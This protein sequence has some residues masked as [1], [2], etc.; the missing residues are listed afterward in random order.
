MRMVGL[1]PGTIIQKVA[2]LGQKRY[3]CRSQRGEHTK[4]LPGLL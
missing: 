1:E 3:F 2:K 4:R